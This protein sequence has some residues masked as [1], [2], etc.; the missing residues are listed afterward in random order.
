[1]GSDISLTKRKPLRD[2][3]WVLL[4]IIASAAWIN[5][6]SVFQFVGRIFA[7]ANVEWKDY[8]IQTSGNYRVITANEKTLTLLSTQVPTVT[9]D[10]HEYHGEPVT[11]RRSIDGFCSINVCSEIQDSVL[12]IDGVESPSSWATYADKGQTE[13]I[14]IVQLPRTMIEIKLKTPKQLP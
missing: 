4:F 11:P 2:F 14:E 7:P 9:I 6:S 10:F 8:T 5:Q 3:A 12:T 13:T 1:M